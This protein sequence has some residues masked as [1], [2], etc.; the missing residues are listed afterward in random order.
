MDADFTPVIDGLAADGWTVAHGLLPESV[1]LAL[2]EE[3]R[4]L[5]D[6]DR[7]REA[8]IGT[9]GSEVQREDIRSDSILW[10]D[11]ASAPAGRR[12][13]HRMIEQLRLALNSTLFLG[14]ID[15]E[16]HYAVYEEGAHYDVHVDRFRAS[17]ARMIS[18]VLYL[19][20]G[21]STADGGQLRLHFMDK[22]HDILPELGTFVIFRSDT[23]PHE[24][25][26]STRARYS[27]TGWYRRRSFTDIFP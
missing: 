1:L 16:C 4:Q 10:L 24:V 19:N 17:D 14:L 12:S 2:M 15:F 23:V 18:V 21:W 11:A 5:H 22:M 13:Y 6:S 7:F 26:P 8:R 3:A 25:L 9:G 20:E 27:L